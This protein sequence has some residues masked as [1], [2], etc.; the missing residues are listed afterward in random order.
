LIRR[1]LVAFLAS[2]GAALLLHL[3]SGHGQTFPREP[4]RIVVPFPA[5]GATDVLA[6]VLSHQ[7]QAL[8]G[9]SVVSDYRPGA[10]G[11][12]GTR[13]VAAAPADGHTL[14]MASTGAILALASSQPG[15]A[16][17]D[18]A[19]D[20]APISLIASPPYILVVNPIVPAQSAAELIA[21]ARSNPGKLS[22][23]SSGVGSASHLSGALFAQMAGIDMLHVPYRGTGPAVTDLLGG[24]IEVMFSPA[25]TVTPHIA[26]GTL[27][28]LG[29]TGAERSALFQQFPTIAETGL[30][31]YESLGWFGLFAPAATPREVVTKISSD[32]ARALSEPDAKRRLAE[33]GA[34]PAP[35]AP[36]AFRAFVNADIA[37][38]LALARQAGIALH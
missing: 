25:L 22:F 37:K 17:Y 23:G 5:G 13:Q 34:E 33:Q 16:A 24:R 18:I 4:V 8:W 21:Y 2:V 28:A 36:D 15:S 7:L 3:P 31:G 27:R 10:A 20:L 12:I 30:P 35:N 1:P 26:A 19:R 38:W 32:V 14:L 6:R 11:L 9:Q 29:S